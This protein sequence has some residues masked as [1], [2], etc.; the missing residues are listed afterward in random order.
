MP[1]ESLAGIRAGG[2]WL[3]DDGPDADVVASTRVRLARNLAGFP[4]VSRASEAQR[5]EIVALL[6]RVA[7]PADVASRLTWVELERTPMRDRQLLVERR[8]ISRQLAEGDAP[9]AVAFT[10][11]HS[12]SVMVNEE[13][14]IRLQAMLPGLRLEEAHRRADAIDDAI[15]ACVDYAFD[16]R[17]GY[18][19]ACP[20]NVG[21]GIRVSVMVHVPALRITNEIERVR[22]A[23]RDLNLA[24]RGFD[25]EGTEGAGDFFQVSNQVTLGF[26]EEDL[27]EQFRSSVVPRLVEYERQAR[28]LLV[29]QSPAALD[30]RLH[31]ALAVLRSARL[32]GGEEAL[33]LLSR[34]RMGILMGRLRDVD[35][36]VV[37]GLFMRLQPG[38]LCAAAG[39]DLGAEELREQ[40]ASVARSAF[41]GCARA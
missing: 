24:I 21:C 37:N 28:R 23:A 31:R 20:T 12:A 3:T 40:R 10:P 29:R 17:W 18:L 19:T 30:D 13:D 6:R 2:A 33:K 8:L 7:M 39:R 5:R 14:H 36:A 9:R 16:R 38:H 26:C 41:D 32:L 22:R 35:L 15:E 1:G 11:E 25:G 34:V 27:I 4:F